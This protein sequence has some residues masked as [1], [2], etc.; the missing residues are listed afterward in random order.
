MAQRVPFLVVEL[1]ADADLFMHLYA[2]L[3]EKERRLIAER[4]RAA[5]AARR[6][7]GVPLGKT[8]SAPAAAALGRKVQVS[9]ADRFAAKVLPVIDTIRAPGITSL[10]GI[11]T[12]LNARGVQTA[13]GGGRSRMSGRA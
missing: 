13:R 1:G 12:A 10:R 4:T 6:V 9:E 2:A 5:L 8:D 3:A 7:Q 11:A